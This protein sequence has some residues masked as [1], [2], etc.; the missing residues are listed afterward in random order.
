M[1]LPDSLCTGG[2]SEHSCLT[3]FFTLLDLFR[4]TLSVGWGSLAGERGIRFVLDRF[5]INESD[6]HG[7]A[8]V[9]G[10]ETT[11]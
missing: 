3:S 11:H 5:A 4:D 8:S 1:N 2:L 6:V 9:F 7:I 10:T